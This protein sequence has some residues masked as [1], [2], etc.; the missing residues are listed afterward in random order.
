MYIQYFKAFI[1]EVRASVNVP[2]PSIIHETADLAR[3]LGHRRIGIMATRGTVGARS[4]QRELEEMGMKWTLP[5]ERSQKILGELIYDSVKAGKDVDTDRFYSVVG[6]LEGNGADA[7]ILGCTELSV[8]NR[9]L[10]HDPRLVDSTEA[11]AYYAIGLCGKTPTG[12]PSEFSIWKP[13]Y[14]KRCP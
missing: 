4:Y 7:M 13:E 1:D 3:A 11:L 9:S 14:E 5:S 2:V 10:E 12:F 6:E 8:I